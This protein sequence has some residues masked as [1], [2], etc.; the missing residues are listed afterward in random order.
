MEKQY[1]ELRLFSET[2]AF[3]LKE[4][5]IKLWNE[6]LKKKELKKQ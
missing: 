5:A 4:D 1:R 3:A 2:Q 6:E